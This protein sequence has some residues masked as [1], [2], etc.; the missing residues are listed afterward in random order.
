MQAGPNA[1]KAKYHAC[2]TDSDCVTV[3]GRACLGSCEDAIA[4]AGLAEHQRAMKA[5]DPACDAFVKGP[6][7]Y[8]YPIAVPTCP[9]MIPRCVGGACTAQSR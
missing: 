4:K 7:M 5:T 1:V 6:C 3:P 8:S 2:S 9:M